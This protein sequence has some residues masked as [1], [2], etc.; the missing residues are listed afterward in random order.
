MA[1]G[2]LSCHPDDSESRDC[3][4]SGCRCY[5]DKPQ[6]QEGNSAAHPWSRSR[7]GLQPQRP[8]SAAPR[9]SSSSSRSGRQGWEC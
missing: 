7:A 6:V 9:R 1:C 8:G 3:K 2:L 5:V 4:H